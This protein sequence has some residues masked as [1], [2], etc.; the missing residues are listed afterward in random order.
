MAYKRKTKDE[1]DI[2]C[3]YGFG[4]GFETVTTELTRKEAMARAKE[5]REN[6]HSCHCAVQVKKRRVRI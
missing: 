6:D 4:H 1:Y 2:Q 5:Y 3:N